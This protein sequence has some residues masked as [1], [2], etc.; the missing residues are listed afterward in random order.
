M[1]KDNIDDLAEGFVQWMETG[2]PP[3]GFF[4]SDVLCDF[5]MPHWRLQAKGVPDVLAL[6]RQGHP[7]LGK[8]PR[9]RL[10][11]TERGFVIEFEERREWGGEEWTAR[12]MARADVTGGAISKLSVYCTGDWDAALRAR[13]ASEI[14]LIEP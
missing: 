13:H 8:V 5:T 1:T 6:R 11:K 2:T 14:T 10:D 12:E 9:W 3:E 4:T 7:G